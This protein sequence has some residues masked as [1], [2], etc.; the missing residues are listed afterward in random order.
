[1]I[2]NIEA[3]FIS[4]EDTVRTR[5]SESA[6]VL[7]ELDAIHHRLRQILEE[8]GNLDEKL[9]ANTP[10]TTPTIRK[11]LSLDGHGLGESFNN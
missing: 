10:A 2:Q 7:R 8:L 1:M 4:L 5:I 11:V 6:A 3:Y 9:H